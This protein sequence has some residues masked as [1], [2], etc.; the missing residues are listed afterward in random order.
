MRQSLLTGETWRHVR[1]IFL[2][3]CVVLIIVPGRRLWPICSLTI[4]GLVAES[5][6]PEFLIGGSLEEATHEPLYQWE[7]S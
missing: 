5:V 6:V 4:E 3:L 1:E 7:G 2:P